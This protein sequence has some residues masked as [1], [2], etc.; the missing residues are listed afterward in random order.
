MVNMISAASEGE[1]PH[2]LNKP[3]QFKQ[4]A[5]TLAGIP[6]KNFYDL[7]LALVA[8]NDTKPGQIL[9]LGQNHGMSRRRLYY[10]LEVGRFLK[11]GNIVKD[12]AERLGWTKFVILARH[13]AADPSLTKEQVSTLLALARQSTAHQLPEALAT[14]T[15]LGKADRALLIRIPQEQY[16]IVEAAL[17]A[18][19]AK[20]HGKGLVGKEAALVAL[21]A[22]SLAS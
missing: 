2:F 16:E 6:S 12:E 1:K 20:K 10:L 19:G 3:R 11:K 18:H 22:N 15:P 4:R 14:K 7:A 5:A 21:A 9:K 13:S 8:V 17:L